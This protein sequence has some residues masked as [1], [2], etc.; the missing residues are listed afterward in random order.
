MEKKVLDE[1][2]LS[3]EQAHEL[4]V[5]TEAEQEYLKRIVEELSRPEAADPKL[6]A[7]RYFLGEHRVDGRTWLEHG[8]IIFSQYYDTAAWV[9]EELAKAFSGSPSRYMPGWGR[10]DFIPGPIL[11]R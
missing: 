9:A 1:E 4:S 11:R 5:L 7:V 10:A 8:C 6:K 3:A 2:E